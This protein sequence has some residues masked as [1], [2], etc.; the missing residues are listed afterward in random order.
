MKYPS[1]ITL[2][3][4]AANDTSSENLVSN[5]LRS[6]HSH[7]PIGFLQTCY[8]YMYDSSVRLQ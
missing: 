5:N 4:Q 6:V 3:S 8:G 2:I 1:L 7:R